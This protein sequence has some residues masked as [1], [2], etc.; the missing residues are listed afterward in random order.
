MV[1]GRIIEILP[2]RL[3]DGDRPGWHHDVVRIWVVSTHKDSYDECCVFA[4]VTDDLPVL[5]SEVWWQSRVIYFDGDKKTLTK[6][7]Y[8]FNPGG[9]I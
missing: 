3:T 1:G 8:S 5:G 2:V 4:E 9:S 7:G 6:V